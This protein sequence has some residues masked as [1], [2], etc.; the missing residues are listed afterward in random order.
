MVLVPEKKKEERKRDRDNMVLISQKL[1][2]TQSIPQ[3]IMVFL[4]QLANL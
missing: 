4:S 1:G 2:D 3:I